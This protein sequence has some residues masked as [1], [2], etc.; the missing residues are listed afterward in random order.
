MRPLVS[1]RGGRQTAADLLFSDRTVRW[2]CSRTPLSRHPDPVRAGIHGRAFPGAPVRRKPG[3]RRSCI[4]ARFIM[5]RYVAQSRVGIPALVPRHALADFSSNR[6]RQP[7]HREPSR[8]IDARTH[9][10]RSWISIFP[11]SRKTSPM[12]SSSVNRSRPFPLLRSVMS[13]GRALLAG[14]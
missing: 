13:A 4:H 14:R 11:K 12:A 7:D 3:H 9:R 1:G 2:R 10:P 8:D 5:G 6:H